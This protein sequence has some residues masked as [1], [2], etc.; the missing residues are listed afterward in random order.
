M[1]KFQ[2]DRDKMARNLGL[3]LLASEVQDDR[4]I[5]ILDEMARLI[6]ASER[7]C[8]VAQAANNEA[9]I[10]IEAD[11]LEELIGLTF[12]VLQNKIGRVMSAA[13]AEQYTAK[14][15]SQDVRSDRI[16]LFWDVANYYKHRD[17]WGPT[18]WLEECMPIRKYKALKPQIETR[19]RVDR[20]GVVMAS[21]G[22]LRQVY[23]SLGVHIFSDCKKLAVEV[24]QWADQVLSDA[25]AG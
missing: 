5:R 11:Y 4:Y 24:Q 25:N 8:D 1:K 20:L 22:N 19:R 14:R 23:E 16:K 3:R 6:R 12:V 2:Y 21:T 7:A 10:E 9:L 15:E 17:E 18:V 13:S